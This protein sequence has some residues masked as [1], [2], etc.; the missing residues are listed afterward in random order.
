MSTISVVSKTVRRASVSRVQI[1]PPPLNQAGSSASSALRRQMQ[2]LLD[3]GVRPLKSMAV[4]RSALELVLTGERLANGAEP[5]RLLEDNKGRGERRPA[6]EVVV[7]V[8]GSRKP[9]SIK[10]TSKAAFAG[11][12]R[13]VGVADF[14]PILPRHGTGRPTRMKSTQRSRPR[15]VDRLRLVPLQHPPEFVQ[16]R[17]CSGAEPLPSSRT[18]RKPL[19]VRASHGF[20]SLLPFTGSSAM[21]RAL[22]RRRM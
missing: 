13:P 3:R 18:P 20:K 8:P 4:Q 1:P 15:V 19:G 16:H 6:L 11:R 12:L 10:R 9:S 5:L 2:R 7:R 21:T 14:R 17:V 22:I